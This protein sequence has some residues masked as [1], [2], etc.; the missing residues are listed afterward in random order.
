VASW[1]G[2]N[3]VIG[4]REARSSQPAP[5]QY[6]RPGL[7]VLR[8][9][10]F[11]LVFFHH[12]IPRTPESYGPQITKTAADL[13]A[14]VG[15]ACGFGLPLF[16]FLSAYLITKLLLLEHERTGRIHLASFY[17][18]R[19]LRIWPLYFFGLTIGIGIALASRTFQDLPMFGFFIA[20]IGN[21]YFLNHPWPSN[22]MSP[23]WSLSVEEQ[24]YLILPALLIFL[25]PSRSKLIGIAFIA[26]S[27]IALIVQGSERLA[28]DTTIWTNTLSQMIF[29]GLGIAAATVIN[30]RELHIES[31][32]CV[33]LVVVAL[34]LFVWSADGT[35][36]KRIALASSG[37]SVA[38]GYCLVGLGCVALLIA[39]LGNRSSYWGWLV[40][41]GKISYGLYVYHELN[42]YIAAWLLGSR[43]AHRFLGAAF[44]YA[45]PALR[46]ATLL[47]I[48]AMAALSYRYLETPF[49]ELR[50]RFTFIQNRPI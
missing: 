32:T 23:L 5:E 3:A 21:F 47:P 38:F 46:I 45:A 18:R 27:I 25:R 22:P 42:L 24:F 14:A 50:R 13:F 31:F 7:D 41:L 2:G 15:N 4:N 35:D 37:S 8:L 19:C 44:P 10:A 20:F 28:S 34:V 33:M 12:I 43:N 40:Y 1:S 11:L 6:Y 29:F 48:V 49:L 26:I 36:V 16:F 39:A 9:F 30:E 17:V